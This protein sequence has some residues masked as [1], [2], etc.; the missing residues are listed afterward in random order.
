MYISDPEYDFWPWTWYHDQ[1]ECQTIK[2]L[3]KAWKTIK[4]GHDPLFDPRRY[5][6][7][8]NAGQKKI[9]NISN[10]IECHTHD[11]DITDKIKLADYKVYALEKF[12]KQMQKIVNKHKK[13]AVGLSGG[14]DST[15]TLGWLK[16][17]KVDFESF[18]V[19]GD[20]WRGFLSSI[21]EDN[22]IEM[23]KTLGVTNH[24]IDFNKT[25][26]DK[27]AMIKQYCEADQYDIPCISLVT[28]PPASMYLREK[29]FDAMIVA[30]IGTDDLFLHRLNSW[31]RFIPEKMLK[32]CK[33]YN[34]PVDYITDYGYKM[35]GFSSGWLDKMEWTSGIQTMNGWEDDLLF[36]VYKGRIR[37][38]A[39]SKE[40]YEMWHKIDDESCDYSQLQDIMG[41]GWLKNQ[42]GEWVGDNVVG[43]IK[44]VICTENYY[45]PNAENKRY[46]IS[47]CN[48]WMDFY[49]QHKNI[50][51]QVYWRSA[52]QIISSWD[53]ISPDVV[54]SIHTLNWLSKNS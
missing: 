43:L 40:W 3:V 1:K 4:P 27:H 16:K 14:I 53:K 21:T 31:C 2:D 13:V 48:R 8:N 37:S 25:S 22:A 23:S 45:R 15:M 44:G 20:A 7:T 34:M 54:Q 35:G 39:M 9:T 29:I 36:Q 10:N 33:A 26:Y 5:Q 46:I 18:V 28:Q 24:V 17:N 50:T 19:R 38:P 41:V 52:T 32:I 12:D 47:E 30:P 51:Q 42:I 49:K 6:H 11:V